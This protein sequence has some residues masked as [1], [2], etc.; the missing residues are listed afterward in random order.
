MKARFPPLTFFF[1]FFADQSIYQNPPI[2]VGIVLLRLLPY[3]IGCG[4]ATNNMSC[5]SV[6][7][8]GYIS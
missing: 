7:I 4:S 6:R 5:D 1:F 3:I 2:K 8:G